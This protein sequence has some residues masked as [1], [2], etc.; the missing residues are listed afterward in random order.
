[1]Y[2]LWGR[3]LRCATAKAWEER[4]SQSSWQFFDTSYWHLWTGHF[5]DGTY[6]SGAEDK[7]EHAVLDLSLNSICRNILG[8]WSRRVWQVEALGKFVLLSAYNFF[9]SQWHSDLSLLIGI[10]CS[11]TS[12]EPCC[13]KKRI[14][15][16]CKI[17]VGLQE[18]C[19]SDHGINIGGQKSRLWPL[20]TTN[21]SLVSTLLLPERRSDTCPQL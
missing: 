14:D 6:L 4:W 19:E 20:W 21:T 1:M 15:F 16:W 3:G 11:F 12:R 10:A 8:V 17:L 18:S 13:H 9:P 5:R 7:G 2:M